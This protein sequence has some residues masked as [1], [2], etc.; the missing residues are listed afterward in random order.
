MANPIV[1]RQ[2]TS[3][4][5]QDFLGLGKKGP[6]NVLGGRSEPKCKPGNKRCGGACVPA[7]R[8]G[9]KTLCA[10]EIELAQ[11]QSVKG[12]AKQAAQMLKGVRAELSERLKDPKTRK[13]LKDDREIDAE[14]KAMKRQMTGK[15][16]QQAR[17]WRS[18]GIDEELEGS[19][20][21]VG[22]RRKARRNREF[23]EAELEFMK[24]G[25]YGPGP[26]SSAPGGT[27][28]ETRP[29]LGPGSPKPSTSGGTKT[30]PRPALGSGPKL[31]GSGAAG[32]KETPKAKPKATQGKKQWGTPPKGLPRNYTPESDASVLGL[33]ASDLEGLDRKALRGIRRKLAAKYHPDKGGSEAQMQKVNAAFDNI[34][35]FFRLDSAELSLWL[36]VRGD[37]ERWG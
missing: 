18:S 4:V 14:L 33:S 20:L 30:E 7:F 9:Q 27:K 2:S 28:T 22:K 24:R 34:A 26:K 19:L 23:V 32:G 5:R 17:N 8:N 12:R 15:R 35:K 11:K 3:V 25:G 1:V 10:D 36:A 16:A 31:P 29:A 13:K 6:R 21:D 37:V